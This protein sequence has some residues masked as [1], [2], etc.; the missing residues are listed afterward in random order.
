M[1]PNKLLLEAI[2]LRKCIMATYNRTAF[3]LAPH[4]LYTRHDDLFVDAVTLERDGRRPREIKLGAFKLAGLS[5]LALTAQTFQPEALFDPAAE[6]YVE[7]TV[8]AVEP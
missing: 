3:K 7:T 6:R 8:F 2:A 4:I 5:E 1:Q